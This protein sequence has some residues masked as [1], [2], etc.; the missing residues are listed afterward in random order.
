MGF[1]CLLFWL[2]MPLA[3]GQLCWAL[4]AAVPGGAGP[5]EGC[6]S[7]CCIPQPSVEHGWCTTLWPN[8]PIT[9]GLQPKTALRFISTEKPGNMCLRD[10]NTRRSAKNWKQA[11]SQEFPCSYW[12]GGDVLWRN[13]CLLFPMPYFQALSCL[14]L[15]FPSAFPWWEWW[16]W[17]GGVGSSSAT[18]GS[19]PTEICVALQHSEIISS[20]WV[21][22]SRGSYTERRCLLS[23]I[24]I[25]SG[26]ALIRL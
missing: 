22:L 1:L 11:S 23:N 17:S 25:P 20:S 8:S 4:P 16:Y 7:R 13:L 10:I 5:A 14:R 2:W 18:F 26:H 15:H 12:T 9:L 6:G 3:Q 21:S 19:C 24:H